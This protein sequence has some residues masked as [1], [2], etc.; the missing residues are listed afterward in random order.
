MRN[1]ESGF[2][3]KKLESASVNNLECEMKNAKLINEAI[4]PE[5]IVILGATATGK[6]A[7]ALELAEKLQTEIISADSMMVYKNFNIGTAKPTAEEL[8]RVKHHLVDILEPEKRFSVADFQNA[9]SKIII[10]LNNRGK[11]PIVAGGTGLYIQALIEGY[12]FKNAEDIDDNGKI[13][14]S[15]QSIFK[16]TG[17]LAYNVKVIGLTMDRQELYKRINERTRKMFEAGLVDEVRNLLNSGIS[18]NA[19]AMLGIGYKETIEY[20]DGKITL[21]ETIEKISQATRNFAKRQMTWYRR[22]K[23]IEWHNANQGIDIFR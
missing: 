6:S 2:A 5:L 8:S 20:I 13:N 22:M 23:Y 10:D 11:I 17:K 16:E 21:D 4:E 9:A 7:L 1:S 19:Q 14:K 3:A 12:K 18:R 15:F